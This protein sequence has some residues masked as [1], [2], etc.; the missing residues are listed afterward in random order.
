MSPHALTLQ[1]KLKVCFDSLVK[2][3]RSCADYV[4]MYQQ[5]LLQ[6]GA[7]LAKMNAFTQHTGSD[8]LEAPAAIEHGQCET[9][10]LQWTYDPKTMWRGA[11]QNPNVLSIAR[12]I[13]AVGFRKDCSQMSVLDTTHSLTKVHRGA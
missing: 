12:S 7:A 2:D 13:I 10:L 1:L 6:P 3:K 11:P 8:P 5:T 4:H 9:S